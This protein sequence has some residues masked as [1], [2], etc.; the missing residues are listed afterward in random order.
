MAR[1]A[2]PLVLAELGGMLMVF[3]DTIMVGRVSPAAIGAVSLGGILFYTVSIF[4]AGI[5]LGLDTLVSQSF[6]AGRLE[7]CHRSLLSG[8]YLVFAL[9]PAL[10]GIVWLELPLLRRFGIHPAVLHDVVPFL[11]ALNWSTLPLLLYFVFRRY[12][13]GM[14]LA[15]PVMMVLWTA[16]VVNAV[17]NWILI[18]GHWGAPPMGAE[19]SAWST[20]AA[21]VY[22][23][24][25]LL[26][27]ILRHDR[28]H[29]TGLLKTPLA[30]DLARIR[31]LVELG[32]PAATQIG[33]EIGVFAVATALIGKLNPAAL[34]AH[35]IA[36]NVA[37]LTYMVPLG[38]S[39]AAAVRV[40]QALGRGDRRAAA[41]AGWTAMAL[42]AS[43][44]ALAGLG[45]LLAPRLIIRIFTPDADVMKLG[46]TLLAVAAAFQLFDGVQTVSTGAL[47]GAGD[48]RTPMLTHLVAYWGVG[49]PLGY[50]LCF[51]RGWG[52]A[53]LWT[54]LCVAL[55]LIGLALGLAWKMKVQAMKVE[56]RVAR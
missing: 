39:A 43:F 35:Q 28:R 36:M 9:T 32:L 51:A 47:R 4:G 15:K 50:F 42:G 18:Y 25:V 6:G 19:G 31:S 8:V 44:M 29:R 53:G 23:A 10:M 1:L 26:V 27:V 46:V 12:L 56:A 38:I 14:N 45:L 41:H 37:T 20:A 55:I 2:G 16:N 24:V 52:A 13:Q 17:G 48:T 54:G 33:L 7:D 22:M 11:K 30:P 5:T 40:G 34:A 21:R 49:L 3:V